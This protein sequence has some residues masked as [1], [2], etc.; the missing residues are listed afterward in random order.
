VE[1]YE[2]DAKN[3]AGRSLRDIGTFRLQAGDRVRIVPTAV[4]VAAGNVL[5]S[6][7]TEDEQGKFCKSYMCFGRLGEEMEPEGDTVDCDNCLRQITEARFL[8]DEK[9]GQTWCLA[10]RNSAPADANQV[11]QALAL[12]SKRFEGCP[13]KELRAELTRLGVKGISSKNKD[14]LKK[15]IDDHGA[16]P[17]GLARNRLY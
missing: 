7:W 16:S 2:A 17:D 8:E 4:D 12:P 14:D 6:R 10:C 13:N 9:T 15:L 1:V 11:T 5:M 3:E